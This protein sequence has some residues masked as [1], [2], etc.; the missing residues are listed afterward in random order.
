VSGDTDPN[1]PYSGGLIGSWGWDFRTQKLFDPAKISDIMGYC[2]SKWIS[3]YTYNAFATRVAAVNGVTMIYE[4]EA[5]VLGRWRA[6]WVSDDHAPRWRRP[7][8]EP[9][10][11]VGEPEPAVIYDSAGLAIGEVTV[12]RTRIGDTNNGARI[13]IP[14]PPPGWYAIG[15]AGA[16]VVPFAPE[17]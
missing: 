8:T 15:V 11:A 10:P 17:N 12:Y 7:I 6:L 16:P 9:S 14:E 2:N 3:D 4:A 5:P 1:Y 13:L